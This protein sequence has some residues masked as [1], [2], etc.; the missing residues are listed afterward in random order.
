MTSKRRYIPIHEALKE[1]RECDPRL[2]EEDGLCACYDNDHSE[3]FFQCKAYTHN[4]D[5]KLS[6]AEDVEAYRV[7]R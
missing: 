7:K 4:G 5:I 3:A 6:G 1:A 2:T